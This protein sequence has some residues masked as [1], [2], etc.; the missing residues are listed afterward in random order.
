MGMDGMRRPMVVAIGGD[1]SAA[2]AL[3]SQRRTTLSCSTQQ[4]AEAAVDGSI[5]RHTHTRTH[6]RTHARCSVASSPAR[7]ERAKREGEGGHLL[8]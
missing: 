4:D 2:P 5:R 1:I 7:R 8:M 6:A 3:H